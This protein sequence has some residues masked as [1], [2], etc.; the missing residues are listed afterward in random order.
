[1]IAPNQLS[2][3]QLLKWVGNQ[4]SELAIERRQLLK[5]AESYSGLFQPNPPVQ[6]SR[7]SDIGIITAYLK[8]LEVTVFDLME[9]SE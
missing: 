6:G 8:S 9:G 5:I 4:I 7:L 3:A 1:M 2:N